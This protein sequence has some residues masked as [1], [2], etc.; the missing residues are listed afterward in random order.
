MT[1]GSF[2]LW[3]LPLL[4]L[5]LGTIVHEDVAILSGAYLAAAGAVPASLAL[6]ALF[7]GVVA[8][9]FAVYAI[10][11][12]ARR[13]AM[14]GRW[15][16]LRRRMESAA[17]ARA[18]T[19][20]EQNAFIVVAACR[21]LPMALFPTYAACGWMRV[22]FR[23]FALPVIV[24]AAVYVPV[25]FALCRVF[26]ES[27]A[28]RL[29]QWG[30]LVAAAL[31]AVGLLFRRRIAGLPIFAG[32]A[33]V[34]RGASPAREAA[35]RPLASH[36]GMPPLRPGQI[37]VPLSE[38]INEQLFYVPLV[39]QW[40]FL[41]ARYG[42]LTLPTVANPLIEAG[43][44]LGESKFGYF[45]MAGAAARPWLARTVLLEPPAAGGVAVA[46]AEAE[47]ALAASGLAYPVVAKPDIAW[48][49]YGCR[50]VAD[51][52]AL[53]DYLAAFPAGARLLLQEYVPYHG[54][55]GVFYV[56]RPGA[57]RGEIVSLTFRYYPFVVGDG[58]ATLADLIRG[59]PRLAR[60]A[61]MHLAAHRARLGTVPAAGEVVRLALVGSNRVGGLYVDA[62]RHITPALVARFDAIAASIP[63]FHFGRF[64][65]RFASTERFEAGEDFVIVEIN[66]AGAEAIHVWDPDYRLADVY[67][68]LFRQQALMFRI[69][70]ANRRRG[71]RPMGVLDLVRTQRRQYR[72]NSAYPES[73]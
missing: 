32:I 15:A 54:E 41:G 23:R 10:G 49:G 24:S 43:G 58:R 47:A 73:S 33:S 42:S 50:L 4:A 28:Q 40:L 36:P 37:K 27:L 1:T 66:G 31:L 34:S 25:V 9:D 71:Y 51:R 39:A 13:G 64:D 63:E 6:L 5:F 46:L 59:N 18:Q 3:A 17:A 29:D 72:L 69:A 7:A 12:A 35:A 67:R 48:R 55:A 60:K 65:L 52:T 14:R 16:W 57:A 21:I 26:G 2:P 61:E 53:R 38:R 19:W 22:P 11:A 30:W 20:I 70:A 62:G 44:L 68:V 8:G 45:D 56:R